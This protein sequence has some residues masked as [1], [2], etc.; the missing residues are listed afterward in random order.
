MNNAITLF[1]V[2]QLIP[3]TAYFYVANYTTIPKE[4]IDN[5]TGRCP[6]FTIVKVFHERAFP[7][8]GKTALGFGAYMGVLVHHRLLTSNTTN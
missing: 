1:I 3:F 6:P 2:T 8:F 7:Y 4:Y 5:M